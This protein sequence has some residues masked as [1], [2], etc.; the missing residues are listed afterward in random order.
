MAMDIDRLFVLAC[1]YED[2]GQEFRLFLE[3]PHPKPSFSRDR[4]QKTNLFFM[5]AGQEAD[6]IRKWLSTRKAWQVLRVPPLTKD[7]GIAA[8]RIARSWC[9][10]PASPFFTFVSNRRIDGEDH[11]DE[12]RREVNLLIGSIIENPVHPHEYA[13]LSLLR[14]VIESAL[15][16]VELATFR[17]VW[18]GQARS[19]DPAQ[20]NGPITDPDEATP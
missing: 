6:A 15:V 14:E 7:R 18:Q 8:I 1:G 3:G 2:N 9:S 5:F 11:R 10:G 13:D 19:P 17:E 16:N 12:L 20:P 4:P